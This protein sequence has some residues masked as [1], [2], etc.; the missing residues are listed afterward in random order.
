MH[1]ILEILA[2]NQVLLTF[3]LV[4]LGMLIG[5]LRVKG[6]SLGAAA[7]LFVAIAVSAL[8]AAQPEPVEVLILPEIGALGLA[9]FAFAIGINSGPNF[10][11][12]IKTSLGPLA[13]I[14]IILV[15]GALVAVGVGRA[16]GMDTA[17]IAGTY[18]GAV[19]NTPA[20]SAAG[21]ASGDPG[22]ATVGYS[23]AYIFGVLGM[24]GFTYLA[25]QGAAKD[26]DVPSP[27]ANQTIRVER[28]DEITI[29]DLR[30]ALD[31]NSEL[32][33]SRLRRGE[34]GPIWMPGDEDH[35]LRD[36]LV[37]LVGTAEELEEAANLLGHVSTHSLLSDR[38]YLDFRRM[39]VSDARLAGRAIG[40]LGLE[41]KY[42]ATVSRVRRGDID[43]MATPHT[44]LQLGDRIRIV[45]PSARIDELTR[46]FGD[47]ARGMTHINPVALGLGLALGVFIGTREI[48][49]GGGFE[50]G[51]AA[52][53]LLVGLVMGRIGRIGSFVTTLP[54]AVCQVVSELG[55]LMFLA[56]AGTRAGAQISQAFTSGEWISIFVVG[57][58][59]TLT[60][61]T[62]LYVT[63][64][65][66]FRTGDTKLSGIFG[67]VQ[68][69][70]AVLGFAN[71]R[72][73]ADPR[74][75]LGYAMAYP[76]AMVAKI[77]IA[78]VLG[79]L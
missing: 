16:F 8:G 15:I 69:Q 50:L 36:D 19:T 71:D 42:G 26:T 40:E 76:L 75:A 77:L 79:G 78:Q 57:A 9:L 1:A 73:G 65:F 64:H 11:H 10:F 59:T 7:V 53:A 61:G 72:T 41:E 47:S 37:T 56:Q 46:F 23:I 74:V 34:T 4:G 27:V 48:P 25:L 18:A 2:E 45:A 54:A 22:L 14:L 63:M 12:T 5:H 70:P 21:A 20:L 3:A 28:G 30:G 43:M 29:A 60:I 62:L 17:L 38:R 67:G 55:L 13:A 44:V 66:F 39:T 52:G 51:A 49:I 58:T 6:I 24:L 68:T 31:P 33:I 35:L 32:K